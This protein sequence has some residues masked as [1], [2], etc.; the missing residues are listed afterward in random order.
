[1]GLLSILHPWGWFGS[2]LPRPTFATQGWANPRP[3]RG[4][5]HRGLDIRAAIGTP[6]NA[7]GSGTVKAAQFGAEAGNWIAIEHSGGLISRYLHLSSMGVQPGQKVSKGQEIGRS[8]CTGSA[9]AGPHLHMDT[10]VPAAQLGTFRSLFGD[11]PEGYGYS[12]V[13]LGIGIKVPAEW[14]VPIDQ[15][16]TDVLEFSRTHQMPLKGGMERWIAAGALVAGG[17]VAWKLWLGPAVRRHR[18]GP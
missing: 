13:S 5:I 18:L 8:G 11:P 9:C 2:P 4:D 15:Y 12:G 1:M 17:V 3:S 14:L 16:D 6:V 7:I 10:M